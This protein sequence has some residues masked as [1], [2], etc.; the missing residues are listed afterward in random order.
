MIR[1]ILKHFINKS[2][3]ISFDIFDTLIER[4]VLSPQ[5]VFLIVGQTVLGEADAQKFLVDRTQAERTARQNAMNGEVTLDEIYACLPAAYENKKENLK[6][7]EIQTELD[8]CRRKNSMADVYQYAIAS[9][10][11][12][13]LISDMYLPLEIIKR[14]LSKCGISGYKNCYV[15]CEQQCNKITGELFKK[16]ISENKIDSSRMIH[17]GDSIQAD[18]RGAKRARIKALLISRKNRFKRIWHDKSIRG[19]CR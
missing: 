17:I 11:G 9:G 12:V 6:L 10:K 1:F 13:Y 5:D 4:T 7:A 2:E 16:V 8:C 14:M 18:F 3:V 15:S 19:K